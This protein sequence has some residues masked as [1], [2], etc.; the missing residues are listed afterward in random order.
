MSHLSKSHLLSQDETGYYY[1]ADKPKNHEIQAYYQDKYYQNA[2][3][4]YELS[5][6]EAELLYFH[7]RLQRIH[8]L[9]DNYHP[10]LKQRKLLDVGCG[11]GFGL[12]Y[13]LREGYL[14]KGIDFSKAGAIKQN[15]HVLDNL[16]TGDVFSLL[17]QQ[18]EDGTMYDI[19]LLLNVLEHVIDPRQICSLVQNLLNPKGLAIFTVPNDF[20][21]TQVTALSASHIEHEFWIGPPDHLSYFNTKTL[22]SFFE[23]QNWR[24][25]DLISDFPVDWFLFSK[26]SNYVKNPAQ[27]K[28]AH[29]ARVEIENMLHSNDL[30]DVINFYRAAA[31][32]GVG[33]DI[34]IVV[35]PA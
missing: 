19:I 16:H 13:F 25:L 1:I 21:L 23:Q 14:V 31:K 30:I 2:N 27:G 15:P 8:W 32:C 29:L 10:P 34:T 35:H 22:V 3:G 18:V 4:S 24:V 33:R 7:N 5:Y 20:S 6:S 17:N 28:S 26:G 11:E 9:I 12:A